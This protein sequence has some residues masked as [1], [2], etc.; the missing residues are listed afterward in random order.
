VI[1]IVTS[2]GISCTNNSVMNMVGCCVRCQIAANW[3]SLL[4]HWLLMGSVL[5]PLSVSVLFF[6]VTCIECNLEL[7]QFAAN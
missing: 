1:L 2:G 3:R 4:W 7:R 6:G 5:T